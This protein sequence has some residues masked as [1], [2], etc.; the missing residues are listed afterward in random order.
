[1]TVEEADDTS[2]RIEEAERRLD[3]D[4]GH[5]LA[6]LDRLPEGRAAAVRAGG[7]GTGLGVSARRRRRRL[8][9][10]ERCRVP[11]AASSRA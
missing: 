11:G 10:S 3:V 8:N 6:A 1:M 2:D 5:G 9:L 7:N 4:S